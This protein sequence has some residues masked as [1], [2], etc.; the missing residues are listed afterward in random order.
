MKLSIGS[1]TAL[2]RRPLNQDAWVTIPDAGLFAVADGVG[3][4][5][6]GEVASALA[7]RAL[8]RFFAQAD[9]EEREG[10]VD[11]ARLDL[12]F[13][14]A[15]RD[16]IT[17]ASAGKYRSM[18]TTLAAVLVSGD[19]AVVGHTGD[20]RV[21]RRVE[22]RLEQLTVDHNV[23]ERLARVEGISLLSPSLGGALTRAL[24]PRCNARPDL[25]SISLE[26]G[27][28]LLLCTDGVSGP[29]EPYEIQELLAQP[30]E[31]AAR[32]LVEEA[33]AVGGTD[34]ATAVVIRIETA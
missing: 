12:A 32:G 31:Q 25:R 14:M 13:R 8:E 33:I 15:H 4:E 2:G 11:S 9:A 20:S 19:R 21:Y 22:G 29:L 6:G 1:A 27:D 16:I 17:E 23:Y 24:T 26:P 7:I 3:G 34:N 5:P 28:V 30:P 10:M 18:G